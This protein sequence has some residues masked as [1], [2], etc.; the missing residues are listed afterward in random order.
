MPLENFDGGIEEL[1]GKIAQIRTWTYIANHRE[2]LTNALFWQEKTLKIEN[3]LSD[4][5]HK[6]LTNRFVDLSASYF[7]NS[8]LNDNKPKVEINDNKSIILNGQKYGI[9]N[10][11]Q[12]KLDDFAFSRSLF[13]LSHVKKSLRNMIE[14]KISSFLTAPYDSINYGVASNLRLDE[15]IKLYWGD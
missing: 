10:G 9:I 7:L 12:L 6:S 2:W 11:F 13:S 8:G 4:H 15:S 1:S 14:D 5:L 3:N